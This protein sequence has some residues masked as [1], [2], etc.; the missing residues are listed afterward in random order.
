MD[1]SAVVSERFVKH[2]VNGKYIFRSTKYH[3][4]DENNVPLVMLK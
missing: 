2:P 3:V 4:H 1:K